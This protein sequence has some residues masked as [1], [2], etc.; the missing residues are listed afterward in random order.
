[1]RLVSKSHFE[2]SLLYVEVWLLNK[3]VCPRVVP[4]NM[5]VINMVL[6]QQLFT[7]L[8]KCRPI[9]GDYLGECSPPVKDVLVNP[10]TQRVCC[11]HSQTS[12]LRPVGE[13]AATLYDVLETS[14]DGEMHGVHMHFCKQRCR[15]GNCRRYEDLLSLLQLAEE[16]G[17]YKPGDVGQHIRPP[18][19][20]D[21]VGARHKVSFVSDLVMGRMEDLHVGVGEG[22]QLVMPICLPP[23]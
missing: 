4:Q 15:E 1:M 2:Q 16:A 6:L 21:D 14:R 8:D 3:A 17:L 10:F 19:V 13:S 20:F 11:L 18:K 9:V 7:S 22:N 23:P 12:E 5:D